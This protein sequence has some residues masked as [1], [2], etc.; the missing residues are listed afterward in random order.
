MVDGAANIKI[1]PSTGPA[2]G[3]HSQPSWVP[4]QNS[5]QSPIRGSSQWLER[6]TLMMWG[7]LCSW[8]YFIRSGGVEKRMGIISLLQ[9]IHWSTNWSRNLPDSVPDFFAK[10]RYPQG[11]ADRPLESKRFMVKLSNLLKRVNFWLDGVSWL[12]LIDW[13]MNLKETWEV[14]KCLLIFNKSINCSISI[15]YLR[16]EALI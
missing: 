15:E 1:P 11:I 13:L 9:G 14:D 2:Q 10:L 4:N 7:F 6:C 16:R 12:W 3:V 8:I 5:P